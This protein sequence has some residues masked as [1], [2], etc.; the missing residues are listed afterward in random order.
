MITSL[1][2][3]NFLKQILTFYGNSIFVFCC[4]CCFSFSEKRE[5]D[6]V[7]FH[8]VFFYSNN[9]PSIPT[10]IPRIPTQ[11]PRIPSAI[12]HI[13]LIPFPESPFRLL[14]IAHISCIWIILLNG[15]NGQINSQKLM[16]RQRKKYML[17]YTCWAFFKIINHIQLSECPIRQLNI[18]INFL[19][20]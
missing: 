2:V 9:I 14:Q 6:F 15:R 13:P 18:L 20:R 11:I 12:L 16:L 19:R 4:C 7:N 5:L 8:F 17:F 10:L 1:Y 3:S